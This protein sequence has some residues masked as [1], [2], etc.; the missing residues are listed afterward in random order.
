MLSND[1]KLSIRT[2]KL[3]DVDIVT[4]I[5][6]SDLLIIEVSSFDNYLAIKLLISF[7]SL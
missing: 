5:C 2:S 3:Y 6:Q 7:K 4:K 1:C